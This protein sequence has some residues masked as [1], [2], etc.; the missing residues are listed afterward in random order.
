MAQLNCTIIVI[1]TTLVSKNVI[2]VLLVDVFW[3][4]SN[5]KFS[6]Q[7]VNTSNCDVQH[8]LIS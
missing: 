7:V 2:C 3:R 1:V 6:E 4:Y 8:V 5:H